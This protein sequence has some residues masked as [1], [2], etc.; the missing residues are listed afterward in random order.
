MKS[1]L[2]IL[3]L[4]VYCTAVEAQN[5]LSWYAVLEGNINKAPDGLSQQRLTG[6][7]MV[8]SASSLFYRYNNDYRSKIKNDVSF[9]AG[10]GVRME[11]AVLKSLDVTIGLIFSQG[12]LKRTISNE[13]EVL[14]SVLVTLQKTG[15]GWYDPATQLSVYRLFGVNEYGQFVAV[16]AASYQNMSAYKTPGNE[17]IKLILIELPVGISFKIPNTRLSLSGE[18]SGSILLK[19]NVKTTYPVDPTEVVIIETAKNVEKMAWRFGMG[20]NYKVNN[21]ITVGARY[22]QSL[23]S[24]VDYD[25]IK[26]KSFSL[27]LSYMLPALK[28]K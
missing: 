28:I 20:I 9:G 5:K 26:Y 12:Y 3:L 7:Q 13:K 14:D 1:K 21:K 4:S 6:Y 18:V 16:T 25:N 27:Q 24:I 15:N 22:S 19:G 8:D 10:I 2:L 11:Y 17:T 23:N